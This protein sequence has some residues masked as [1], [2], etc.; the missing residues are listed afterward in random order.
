MRLRPCWPP[1]TAMVPVYDIIDQ[2]GLET[3]ATAGS[4]QFKFEGIWRSEN[5]EEFGAT[6]ADNAVHAPIG[7][8]AHNAIG[9]RPI[10]FYP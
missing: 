1:F 5:S 8:E 3:V 10:F 2:V 7:L 4:L 9:S 6:V